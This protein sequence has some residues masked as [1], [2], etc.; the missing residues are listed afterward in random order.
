M[1][2]TVTILLLVACIGYI[3]A[4]SDVNIPDNRFFE[5][6]VNAGVDRDNNGRIQ[7]SE[8]ILVDSLSIDNN[9]IQ[10]LTGIESFKNLRH[11]NCGSN[12]ISTIDLSA[13]T[14]LGHLDCSFNELTSLD[15]SKNLSLVYLD[16]GVNP[17]NA[18][19]VSKN[20]A[21]EE[22][23]CFYNQ[24]TTLDVSQ[25]IKLRVL[26]CDNN[27]LTSIDL[28]KNTLLQTL[29]C[30]SNQLTGLDVSNNLLLQSIDCY[31][32]KITNIDLTKNTALIYFS[33]YLNK[34][35]SLDVKNN[36]SL[37]SLVCTSNP[38]LE[39]ICV[40]EVDSVF[41]KS[42]F[43]KD[44][45][46]VWSDTCTISTALT[47]REIEPKYRI[48]PNPAEQVL[49][50]GDGAVASQVFNI[51]G[52]ELMHTTAE[53]IDVSSLNSGVYMVKIHYHDLKTYTQKLIKQ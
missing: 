15:V 9:D 53:S 6:L 13:N 21:L 32:N 27:G 5:A 24:L 4:Q 39:V 34:L 38:D 14:K 43:K 7:V 45:E 16:C 8:A 37:T 10:D 12:Q 20:T 22:L 3:H 48:Y 46:A 40:W 33:C 17:L 50:L 25:N 52:E 51:L 23:Y 29:S 44:A 18:I 49:Y 11:L 30:P 35:T 28:S 31:S 47:D 41:N 36:T 42:E 2:T 19:N 26:K 1:R